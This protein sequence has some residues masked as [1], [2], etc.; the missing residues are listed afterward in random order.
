MSSITIHELAGTP[1]RV[2]HLHAVPAPARQAA[3]RLTRRGRVVVVAAALVVLA[4]LWVVNASTT[5][6]TH[7][8]GAP[9]DTRTV[10]VAPGHTLWQIASEA[11]PNGDIRQT[12]DDIMR[13][14]SLPS[15]GALQ[16]GT[17]IAVPVYDH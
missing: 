7:D 4:L 1:R 13:L 10:T 5:A 6:A 2:R 14:N 8:A 3:L 16:M 9:V 12:V 15:A 11:N 17:E